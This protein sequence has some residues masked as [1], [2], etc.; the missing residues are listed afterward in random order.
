MVNYTLGDGFKKLVDFEVKSGSGDVCIM[1]DLDFERRSSYE[2]PI[3]ATDRGGLSTTAM[4]K[5]QVTDINDNRPV[6]YPREYNVSLRD[7][8]PPASDIPVIA[9]VATDL[10]A[11]SFGV[12]RY[13]IGAGNEDAIFKI[14]TISGEIF[15]ARPNQLSSQKKM[16]HRLNVS[17]SDGGGMRS[18][19]DAVVFISVI[20][21]SLQSPAFQ[22]PIYNFHVLEDARK[23]TV[24][25]SAVAAKINTGK[26]DAN[27]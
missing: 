5:I 22:Q 3:I 13:S 24:V 21:K 8:P 2:F 26:F 10:D 16:M 15:V 23:G 7:S 17:A 6:F 19:G 27:I 1:A 9:V 20:N 14:D 11:G 4:V 18:V 12:V 25:G